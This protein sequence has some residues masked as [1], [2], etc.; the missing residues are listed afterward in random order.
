MYSRFKTR[1][2]SFIKRPI[3]WSDHTLSIVKRWILLFGVFQLIML[4][5]HM[6]RYTVSFFLLYLFFVLD[7]VAFRLQMGKTTNDDLQIKASAMKNEVEINKEIL[8]LLIKIQNKAPELSKYL[9]EMPVI[10]KNGSSAVTLQNLNDYYDS[11]Q[12]LL[13]NYLIE[14]E[15]PRKAF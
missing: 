15:D 14:H 2:M 8:D 5:I 10:L 7:A 1:D 11:L 12:N 6:D 4:F 13:K 9:I 3:N